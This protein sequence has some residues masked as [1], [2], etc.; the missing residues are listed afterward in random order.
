MIIDH[1]RELPITVTRQLA[2][3]HSVTTLIPTIA[4][5]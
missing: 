1:R 3:R 5:G 4:H 2:E